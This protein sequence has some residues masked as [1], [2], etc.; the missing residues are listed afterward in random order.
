[1]K[2]L[3]G[4]AHLCA[5]TLLRGY[6]LAS[7]AS[8]MRVV[9]HCRILGP[10]Q[11][12]SLGQRVHLLPHTRVKVG[13]IVSTVGCSGKRVCSH[14]QLGAPRHGTIVFWDTTSCRYAAP[15]T[16][17]PWRGFAR[18]R[19]PPVRAHAPPWTSPR[20][21]LLLHSRCPSLSLRWSKPAL[22]PWSARSPAPSHKGKG[23]GLI[24]YGCQQ[25]CGGQQSVATPQAARGW[26]SPTIQTLRDPILLLPYGS[27]FELAAFQTSVVGAR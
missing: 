2:A 8:S 12:C 25:R 19:S 7:A 5:H 26:T 24:G 15:L 13:L 23:L 6:P 16:H 27:A 3:L 9:R 10:S 17:T 11:L 22:L 14:A 1:M 4:V 18:V 21:R 20:L